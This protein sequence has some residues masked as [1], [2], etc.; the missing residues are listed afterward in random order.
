MLH[1]RV[2]D[3]YRLEKE[4][5]KAEEYYNKVLNIDPANKLA[6]YGLRRI[7]EMRKIK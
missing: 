4:F 5:D 3:S 7:E 2:G 6:R 1:I